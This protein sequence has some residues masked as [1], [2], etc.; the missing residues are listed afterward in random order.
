VPDPP[1]ASIPLG[2]FIK[3]LEDKPVIIEKADE[4]M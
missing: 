4:E 2:D 3:Q 1:V